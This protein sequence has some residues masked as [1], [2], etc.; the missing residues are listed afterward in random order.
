M[1]LLNAE[2]KVLQAKSPNRNRL[3]ALSIHV[4][5]KI[6]FFNRQNGKIHCDT[7]THINQTNRQKNCCNFPFNPEYNQ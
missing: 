7:Q 3:K 1:K 4:N 5:C 6:C 2:N